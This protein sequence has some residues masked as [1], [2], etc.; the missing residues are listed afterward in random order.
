MHLARAI[1]HKAYFGDES[2]KEE[3]ISKLKED[4]FKIQSDISKEG[5]NGICF[6]RIDKPFYTDIDELTLS[7]IDTL[8]AYG[9]FY[10]GWETSVVKS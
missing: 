6:Y 7:L 10:D 1:E 3:V 2:K 9:A 4:G 5:V 8:E